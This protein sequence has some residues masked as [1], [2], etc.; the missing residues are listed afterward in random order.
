MA[1]ITVEGGQLKIVYGND[2]DTIPLDDVIMES[3]GVDSVVFKQCTA[4]VV[5]L[6]RS[7]ITIPTSTSVEDLIDKIGVLVDV[8]DSG[9]TNLTFVGSKSDLPSS[10]GGVITLLSEHTYYFTADV[11]LEGDRLVGSQDTVI[12]GASS[13]NCSITSTGLG[14]GVALFTTEWTTPI[15]HI[16]FKDVDTCLNING[17]T[18]APVALD[19]TGV[20]FLNIP[21]IG[22]IST[23]DNWIYSK[24]AFLNSK[25]FTFSGTVGTIGIDNSIFVGSG[26]AGGII[27]L[28]STLNVTRRFRVIYS[29]IVAFGAT[30]G[31]SLIHI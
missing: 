24:G 22:E 12:L 30:V 17:V 10:V 29:S 18:N 27:E 31:L 3:K 8:N 19:W 1:T 15:R 11:D 26:S 4:P 16:T 25:G 2:I 21:N 23:C 28:S 7:T 20:N 14:T 5:E 6:E 9:I 13:E